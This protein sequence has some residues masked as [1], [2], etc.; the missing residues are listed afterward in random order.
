MLLLF[1][2]ILIFVRFRPTVFCLASFL[3]GVVPQTSNVTQDKLERA[4]EMLNE[5]LPSVKIGMQNRNTSIVEA[6]DLEFQRRYA[7]FLF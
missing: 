5:L 3:A 6:C 7:G 4:S 2:F 1:N